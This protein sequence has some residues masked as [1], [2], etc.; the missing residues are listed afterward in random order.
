MRDPV[1]NE[2]SLHFFNVHGGWYEN[3]VRFQVVKL[4]KQVFF[5][6]SYISHQ[7]CHFWS[8]RS[9][10]TSPK[11]W[12]PR[13]RAWRSSLTCS[14]PVVSTSA[15][16]TCWRAGWA[17]LLVPWHS[18]RVRCSSLQSQRRILRLSSLGGQG[19]LYIIHLSKH[20]SLLGPG[21]TTSDWNQ[22]NLRSWLTLPECFWR[23]REK[24][25]WNPNLIKAC[26]L[27]TTSFSSN[28][29]LWVILFPFCLFSWHC[30]HFC[31]TWGLSF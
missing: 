24:K 18:C 4:V 1:G 8:R 3:G 6:C 11:H 27:I 2:L 13:R 20:W 15:K 5:R 25:I 21:W 19:D 9:F 28:C 14:L 10:L 23:S 31:I 12:R 22:Q 7:F 17:K 29:C 16:K 26:I 30:N